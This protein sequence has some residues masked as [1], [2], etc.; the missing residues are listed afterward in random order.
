LAGLVE[1][2]GVFEKVVYEKAV[3]PLQLDAKKRGVEGGMSTKHYDLGEYND[4]DELIDEDGLLSEEDLK[5]PLQQRQPISLTATLPFLGFIINRSY[6][7]ELSA[8][9]QPEATTSLPRLHV[10]TSHSTRGGGSG[11]TGQSG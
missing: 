3:I 1:K 11:T 9:V 6:S 2:D 4:G 5:R 8:R 10:W 7:P